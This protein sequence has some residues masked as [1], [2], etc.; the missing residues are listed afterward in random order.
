MLEVVNDL[1]QP[2]KGHLNG[3]SPAGGG[4]TF[5]Y[6]TRNLLNEQQN[7]RDISERG[8]P[9]LCENTKAP[10]TRSVQ[11]EQSV[12]FSGGPDRTRQSLPWCGG[13]QRTLRLPSDP[14]KTDRWWSYFPSV[15]RIRW[16]GTGSLFPS[17]FPLEESSTVSVSSLH[18]GAKQTCYPLAQRGSAE[19]SPAEEMDSAYWRRLCEKWP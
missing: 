12:R 2:S 17:V 10:F 15:Q 1:P 11:S 3:L 9:F 7:R 16:K 13:C 6:H 8:Q 4:E 5:N 14:S 19:R 18:C